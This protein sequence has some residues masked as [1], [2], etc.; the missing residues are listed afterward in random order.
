M[1]RLEDILNGAPVPKSSE[2]VNGIRIKEDGTMEVNQIDIGK[3][4]QE[5]DMELVIDGGAC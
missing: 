2:D 3:I 4:V 1:E 5:P